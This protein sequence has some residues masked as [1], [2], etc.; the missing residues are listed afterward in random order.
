ME[1]ILSEKTVNKFYEFAVNVWGV[2]PG[3]DKMGIAKKGIKRVSEYYK[4]LNMPLY[5]KD[6][7][8]IDPPIDEIVDKAVR[9]NTI[10]RY[11]AL[12]K[13]DVKNILNKAL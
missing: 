7:N 3:E 13:K 5:L 12:T 8:I 11:V 6:L 1:Y 9:G 2:H 4:S 10:G